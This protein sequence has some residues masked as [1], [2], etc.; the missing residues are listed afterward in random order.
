MSRVPDE[1]RRDEAPLKDRI[2]T[3]LGEFRIIVPALGALFGFQLMAAFSESFQA[4]PMAVRWA[5]FAGV[6]CTALAILFLLIP[7]SDHRFTT[8]IEESDHFLRFAQRSVSFAFAFITA[9]LTLSIYVQAF[10]TSG[11][12]RV[13]MAAGTLLFLALL[14]GWWIVPALEARR[15]GRAR[16]A[17]R[18]GR[19][20]AR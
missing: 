10:R 1:P 2:A 7:A 14:T 6:V 18:E 12:S 17:R 19:P 8:E 11:S 4:L 5:N 13:G 20:Q 16:N 15:R 9:T 3:F